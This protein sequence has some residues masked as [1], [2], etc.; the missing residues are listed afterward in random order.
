M[1]VRSWRQIGNVYSFVRSYIP[2]DLCSALGLLGDLRELNEVVAVVGVEEARRLGLLQPVQGPLRDR[3]LRLA[4]AL[5][6]VQLVGERRL[7]VEHVV[8]LLAAEEVADGEL[9]HVQREES[10]DAEEP[11]DGAPAPA[12]ALDLGERPL[13]VHGDQRRHQLR[14]Q[15]GGHQQQARALHEEPAP[16]TGHEDERLA[17]DAHLQVHRRHQLLRA[18]PDV[19][20]PERILHCAFARQETHKG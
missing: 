9:E 16:S 4:L 19:V 6:V 2:G 10:D 12:D 3:P 1:L 5:A 20:H 7:V 13:R 17:D 18:V 8:P 15:E 11:D 14:R